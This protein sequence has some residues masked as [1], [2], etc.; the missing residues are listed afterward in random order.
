MFIVWGDID[1]YPECLHPYSGYF[2]TSTVSGVDLSQLTVGL[3][4]Y[5]QVARKGGNHL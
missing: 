2:E 5:S 4:L 3:L 1:L